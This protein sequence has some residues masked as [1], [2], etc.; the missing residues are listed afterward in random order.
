MNTDVLLQFAVSGVTV[1]SIYALVALG[2]TLIFNATGIINF[3]QGQ[4]VMLGG[5]IATTFANTLAW[6]LPLAVLAA[7]VLTTAVGAAVEALTIRPMR[8]RSVFTLIM[9]T[10]GVSII[11]E[12][13]ALLIWGTDPIFLSSFS[14]EAPI[15]FFGATLQPQMIWVLGGTVAAMAALWAFYRYTI[16]GQAML[17]CSINV[18]AAASVG[19]NRGR[20]VMVAFALAAA[21]GGLGGVLIAPIT[22]TSYGIGLIMALKG[23]AAAIIGGM[24]SS[25]GAVIGGLAL[26][27]A[28]AFGTGLISSGYKDALALG[29][30]I[31]FLVLR[32]QGLLGGK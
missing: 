32:P 7:I 14:G 30:L 2:F 22:S 15:P 1:G 10:L 27:L 17:A 16:F 26:G 13:A 20:M 31:V 12:T 23:F 24:G 18:D 19:I 6:P 21:L 5:L 29:L 4:F 3:A 9:I 8:G 11:L 25:L 28:E